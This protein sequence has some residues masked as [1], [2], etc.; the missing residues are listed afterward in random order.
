MFPVFREFLE[1]NCRERVNNLLFI[2]F[3]RP[4]WLSCSPKTGQLDK[5]LA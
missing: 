2:F 4:C 1:G 5:V 3:Q